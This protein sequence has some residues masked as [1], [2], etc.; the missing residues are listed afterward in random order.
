MWKIS[1]R[2]LP[3]NL[4]KLHLVEQQ[5]EVNWD[6][7]PW[8]NWSEEKGE[9]T[10]T[11]SQLLFCFC[12]Q[13]KLLLMGPC[14]LWRVLCPTNFSLILENNMNKSFGLPWCNS[15]WLCQEDSIGKFL[16]SGSNDWHMKLTCS[17]VWLCVAD[18]FISVLLI[19]LF[20]PKD[21]II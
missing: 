15:W 10:T 16:I 17:F 18:R 21:H 7:Q 3:G 8:W 5:R 13:L 6:T 1:C 19:L 11:I 9:T 20:V 4:W 12:H 2:E 14:Y